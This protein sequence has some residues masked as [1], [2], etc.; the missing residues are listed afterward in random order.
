VFIADPD[1]GKSAI[2]QAFA[3]EHVRKPRG[4]GEADLVE[5][6]IVE[7]D[8]ASDVEFID[9]LLIKLRSE[10]EIQ[11]LSDKKKHLHALLR[12]H[13]VRM[14]IID[15]LH[16]ILEGSIK[17]RRKIWTII[18]KL[19]NLHQIT[20]VIVGTDLAE[21]SLTRDGQIGSRF[22]FKA[23]L[24]LWVDGPDWVDFLVAFEAT[25]PLRKPSNLWEEKIRKYILDR[26]K[27]VLGVAVLLMQLAAIEAVT[28]GAEQIT[29]EIL[30]RV[31]LRGRS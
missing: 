4:K 27:G 11:R 28:S 20:F 15:E 22:P 2:I 23:E 10:F 26:A 19:A 16:A 18:K 31:N 30:K 8:S 7:P 24:P 25:L 3:E 29:V 9:D 1:T 12:E 6:I 14:I 17:Q 5:L 21:M 13:G